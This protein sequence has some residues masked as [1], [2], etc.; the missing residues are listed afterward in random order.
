[1]PRIAP[2]ALKADPEEGKPPAPPPTWAGSDLEWMVAWWLRRHKI[3]FQYQA[4]FLGGRRALGGQVADFVIP[5]RMLILA[6]QGEY[7]HYASTEKRGRTLVGKLALQAQGWTVVF[8]LQR[9][10]ET[11]LDYVMREG[12]RGIQLFRD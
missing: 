12:L 5:E 7:W 2:A 10:L 9:D 1:M 4:G 6:P 3:E 8:L 11:R